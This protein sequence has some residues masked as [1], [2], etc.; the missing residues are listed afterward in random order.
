[1]KSVA[2]GYRDAAAAI[3]PGTVAEV[4]AVAKAAMGVALSKEEVSPSVYTILK[5]RM[6]ATI[7]RAGATQLDA[8]AIAKARTLFLKLA[9][10][11]ERAAE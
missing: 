9:T 10:A 5:E 4:M 11:L 7:P 1:L 3:Q 6:D 8:A 2:K